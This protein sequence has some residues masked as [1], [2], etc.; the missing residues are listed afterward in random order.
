[1]AKVLIVD[2]T[3]V[4]R[5]RA[6]GLLEESGHLEIDYAENG[7]QALAAIARSQPDLV[8]TD[9]QM[10]EL[11]GLELVTRIRANYPSIPVVIMTAVGSDA[12]A[13]EALE[14]GAASYV[15]KS[16]LNERLRDTVAD[17]L[18]VLR[19]D[20]SYEAL[21]RCQSYAEFRFELE[22]DPALIDLLVEMIQQVIATMRLSDQTGCYRIGVALREALH[23]ALYHGNL[24]LSPDDVEQSREQLLTGHGDLVA[25]RRRQSPYCDRRIHFQ[26]TITREQA[27]FVIR[28]EGPGFDYVSLLGS[29]DPRETGVLDPDSG[30]GFVL[31]LSFMDEVSF[32]ETGSEVTMF[33]NRD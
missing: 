33:K 29:I 2:D 18:S 16:H 20:R 22:N 27:R 31:M 4:D 7:N 17:V 25:E 26:A 1:M 24:Q 14:R 3:A 6:G 32:N 30:R 8:V 10:P 5:R 21:A 19:A 11:D 12:V 15:P 28:D 13:I 23:N 9:L